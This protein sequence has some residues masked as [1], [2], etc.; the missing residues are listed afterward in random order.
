[1]KK[2]N[3]ST[4]IT[5]ATMLISVGGSWAVVNQK[6]SQLEKQTEKAEATLEQMKDFRAEQRV[7]MNVTSKDIT[8][9]KQD[10]KELIKLIR[11]K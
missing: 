2:L 10:I 1:M 8:E 6:V 3:V 9:V 7:M 4:I 5:I 11:E